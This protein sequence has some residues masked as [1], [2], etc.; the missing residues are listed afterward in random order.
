MAVKRDNMEVINELLRLNYDL[1]IPKNNGV[2]AL[3][4]AALSNK[5]NVFNMLV[6]AG[7]DPGFTN[8]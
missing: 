6:D 2:T 7:A 3:G 4:I 5:P 8:R 1:Q